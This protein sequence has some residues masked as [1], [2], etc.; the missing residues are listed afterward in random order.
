MK[1]SMGPVLQ[2]SVSPA[3]HRREV[4]LGPGNFFITAASDASA[5]YPSSFS[6]SRPRTI[7]ANSCVSRRASARA[8]SK[9]H[10]LFTDL[11]D[12]SEV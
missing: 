6:S 11:C 3:R 10:G 5:S 9:A 2:F 7:F 8:P 12:Y 1:P 4:L